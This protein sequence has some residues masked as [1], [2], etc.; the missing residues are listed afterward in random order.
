MKR[1]IPCVFITLAM[2]LAGSFLPLFGF[3]GL[4]LCPLP[5]SVLGCLEGRKSMSAAELMIEATLF[6]AVSPSLAAYFLL[7][8]APVS[9]VVFMLS[10]ESFRDVK[11]LTG[12]ESYIICVAASILFKTLLLIAFWFFTGK[13]ILIPDSSLT[14]EIM[15]QLYGE[16]PELMLSLRQVML[17]LQFLA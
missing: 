17:L 11:K 13:N 7:G 1:I 9:A 6:L 16:S 3:L 12:G 2:M 5:L 8:C 14:A 15:T 4:M 10:Q